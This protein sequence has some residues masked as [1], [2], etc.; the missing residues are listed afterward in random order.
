MKKKLSKSTI[1]LL[2]GIALF[3]VG[4]IRPFMY[5]EA[6]S[7]GY[8]VDATIVEVI[9]EIESDSESGYTS[10]VS[11]VY[12]D[13]TVDGKEYKHVKVGKYYDT[14]KY[15]VGKT[16]KVVVNPNSPGKTMGEGGV[17]CTIGFVVIIYAIVKKIKEK[18]AA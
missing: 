15:Y 17:V 6:I 5:E 2:V 10:T 12:A 13:Y 9:D 1:T 3:L 7:N 11:T 8:E 18:K 4:C 14:D 16:I